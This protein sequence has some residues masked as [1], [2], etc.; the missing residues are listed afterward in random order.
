C[1]PV[2]VGCAKSQGALRISYS[3]GDKVTIDN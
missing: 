1:L 3:F 2:H